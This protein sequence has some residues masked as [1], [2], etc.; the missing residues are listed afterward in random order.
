MHRS[1]RPF[2]QRL[3][4][5]AHSMLQDDIQ[6]AKFGWTHCLTLPQSACGLSSMNTD[7]KLALAAALV[8]ITAYRS[9]LSRRSLDFNWTPSKTKDAS[10]LEAL[11]AS[12][13]V[14]AAPRLVCRRRRS[15]RNPACAGNSGVHP[16]R[17]PP[18]QIH[19][20]LLRHGLDSIPRTAGFT[21]PQPLIWPPFGSGNV[22]ATRSCSTCSL[23][24]RLRSALDA[25]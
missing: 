12:P 4:V 24:D 5:C 11:H 7:R 21:L 9:I 18:S 13:E 22:P 8:W 2:V 6:Q 1:T 20:G 10:V 3:R 16:Q 14:A 25:R 23:A 17:H 15:S 19:A